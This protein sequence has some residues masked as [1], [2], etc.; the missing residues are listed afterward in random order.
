MPSS[1]TG[2][3][4]VDVGG[5]FTDVIAV[6]EGRIQ[7]VKVPTDPTA[8]ERSVIEGARGVRIG[9]TQ[10]FNHASTAGL[11]AVITRRLPKVAFLTTEGHRDMLDIGRSWRPFHAL[12]DANWRRNFGDA[13][14][15]LVPRYLRRGIHERMTAQG[16]IL[17]DLDEGQARS[18][19]SVLRDCNVAGVAICL[20]NSYANGVHEQRLRELVREEL[21]DIACSLSSEVSPLAKEYPRAS[22]TVIDVL[23]KLT[24]RSYSERLIGGLR[25]NDFKGEVNFADCAAMLLRSEYAM[26]QPY[27]VVFA[28]PAAGAMASAHFG[29]LLGERNLVCA[30]VGG[31]S[32]DISVVTDSQPY[33]NTSFELEH[34]L[35]VNALSVDITSIGAGGGSIVGVTSTGDIHVGPDSAGADPGPACYGLGGEAVTVTDI[36]LLSGLLAAD[37]FL[38]GE[39][40]VDPD[41]ARIAVEKLDTPMDFDRRIAYAWDVGINNIAEGLFEVAVKHGIDPRGYTLMAYGAAGP[42]LLPAI[43]TA[44]RVKRVIVPPLPGLFSALGLL[45]TDLVYSDS[46]SAYTVLTEEAATEVD[47]RFRSMEARLVSQLDWMVD[48]G[49][50]STRRSFDGR[51]LGQSWETPF[52]DVPHGPITAATVATMV[53]SFHDVYEQRTG[54]RFEMV[55][56]EAATYRVEVVVPVEKISFERLGNGQNGRSPEGRPITIRHIYGQ[57]QGG[58]EYERSQLRHRDRILGPAIIREDMATTVVPPGATLTVGGFGELTIERAGDA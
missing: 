36:C 54:N 25:S 10:I 3:I 20:L 8:P 31:T 9:D 21:G 6:H 34:D 22:T 2:L 56:V 55:P 47:E 28:G 58:L 17:I 32:C 27:R 16:E 46:R 37:K 42:M 11:N 57:A 24:Y 48:P 39:M 45:S 15:P 41:L 4:G 12:T 13:S 35:L 40:Q 18:Q 7:A 38:G 33:L 43:L 26:A 5:T 19:L 51:L 1:I 53:D 44:T 14:R 29:N 50:I 23:M 30:D 52:V 49:E